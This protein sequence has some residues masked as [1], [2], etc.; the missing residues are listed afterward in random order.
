MDKPS[1]QTILSTK[2]AGGGRQ[3]C[4]RW[5]CPL[6]ELST[7]A[8]WMHRRSNSFAGKVLAVDATRTPTKK[9]RR[10]PLIRPSSEQ[11]K[12]ADL[13]SS[14]SPLPSVMGDGSERTTVIEMSRAPA[15]LEFAERDVME[16]PGRVTRP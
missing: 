7:G 2:P 1:L 8:G 11:A 3:R 14:A 12:P 9:I 13:R 16:C 5:L 4:D 10:L 15:G 6:F